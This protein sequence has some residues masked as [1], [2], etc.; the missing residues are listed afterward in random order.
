MSKTSQGENQRQAKR[1]GKMRD[2]EGKRASGSRE[3]AQR[4]KALATKADTMGSVPGPTLWKVR[5]DY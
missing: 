4:V 5:A 1:K 3:T 2:Q